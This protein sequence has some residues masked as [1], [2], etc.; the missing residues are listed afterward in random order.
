MLALALV[1][2]VMLVPRGSRSA[3]VTDLRP[4]A[5]PPPAPVSSPHDTFTYGRITT[6]DK[7]ILGTGL[8]VSALGFGCVGIRSGLG[9]AV[10]NEDG[11]AVIRT[12]VEHG[13]TF[14]GHEAGPGSTTAN[15]P[16]PPTT[17]AARR[18]AVLQHTADDRT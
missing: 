15:Q 18:A 1:P 3:G 9:P 4:A 13:V 12:A 16:L 11:I 8:E 2:A 6:V 10:N 14:L 5:R 17:M 7:R